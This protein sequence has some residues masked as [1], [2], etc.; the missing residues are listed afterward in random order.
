[1]EEDNRLR[2]WL[3]Y[4]CFSEL[5]CVGSVFC[6]VAWAALMHYIAARFAA[7]APGLS[8]DRL[9]PFNALAQ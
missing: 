6:V 7:Y 4:G 9:Q 1:M 8:R 3:L 5:M 2:V